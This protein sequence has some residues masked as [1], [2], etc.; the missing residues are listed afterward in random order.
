MQLIAHCLCFLQKFVFLGEIATDRVCWCAL[1]NCG[2]VS[3]EVPCCAFG[4]V[5]VGGKTVDQ[6]VV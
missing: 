3:V 1:N 4:G 6:V 5:G 2:A